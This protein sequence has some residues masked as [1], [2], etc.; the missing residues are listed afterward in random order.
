MLT[1][2]IPE[3]LIGYREISGMKSEIKPGIDST[4]RADL[5]VKNLNTFVTERW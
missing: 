2:L 4:R 1:F 3:Q 5:N